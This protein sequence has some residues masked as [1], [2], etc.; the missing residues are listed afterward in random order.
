MVSSPHLWKCVEHCASARF[1][2]GCSF[3]EQNTSALSCPY[4]LITCTPKKLLASQLINLQIV[5]TSFPFFIVKHKSRLICN[6]TIAHYQW[7]LL[8]QIK[9]FDLNACCINLLRQPRGFSVIE[10]FRDSSLL[11]KFITAD[12]CYHDR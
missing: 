12:V 8:S 11:S 1:P 7:K 3:T 5:H 9:I 10:D 2:L 6:D 4:S